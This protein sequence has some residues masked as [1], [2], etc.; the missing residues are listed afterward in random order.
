MYI[1][2]LYLISYT[3]S[4]TYHLMCSIVIFKHEKMEHSGEI[5]QDSNVLYVYEAPILQMY[6]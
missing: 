4:Y 6:Y 2:L 5:N 3:L 1:P